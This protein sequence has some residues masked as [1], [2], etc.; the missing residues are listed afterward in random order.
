MIPLFRTARGAPAPALLAAVVALALSLAASAQSSPP[1]DDV[2]PSLAADDASEQ[3]E[4]V[5]VPAFAGI[6]PR[7]SPERLVND[8]AGILSDVQR[9]S[10]ERMLVAF[11]DSTS[12]QIAVVTVPDLG[13]EDA[14]AFAAELGQ[15]WG[16]GG[17]RHNNGVVL[18]V[19]PRNAGGY[20]EVAI[21]VGYGLEGALPDAICKSVIERVIIPYFRDGD[22]YGG[23]RAGV[24]EIMALASGEI[25]EVRARDDEDDGWAGVAV[26]LLFIA[27]MAFVIWYARKHPGSGGG[28][29]YRGG[30][31]GPTIWTSGGG[32]GG[33]SLGG[34][35]FG[36]GSFGGF[37]GGSFGGG[38][39]SGR[40]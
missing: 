12:N 10:L 17:A 40:F 14:N 31:G 2:L 36:G 39:A 9:E 20:G 7:P 24:E 30:G 25:S 15:L 37:G 19:K 33:G 5:S 29:N 32:R 26:V 22:Y 1:D 16:V 35:S 18:L 38:G 11:D 21:Q 8:L 28:G 3:L 6:P 4:T 34:G 27:L 13:G 23:I